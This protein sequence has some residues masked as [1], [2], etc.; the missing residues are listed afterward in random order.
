MQRT[1]IVVAAA[2]ALGPATLPAQQSN[3]DSVRR[4]K[5]IVDRGMLALGG[6]TAVR[7][8]HRARRVF[9]VEDHTPTQ[10]CRPVEP[11]VARGPLLTRSRMIETI[12]LTQA[13]Y[14]RA[15]KGEIFG[16]QP[17]DFRIVAGD[18]GGFIANDLTRRIDPARE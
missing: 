6:E 15:Q 14:L 10:G 16:G 8:V 4:A 9:E 11:G 12:D 1:A 5:L 18:S 13:R 17:L 7:A 2:L 3:L